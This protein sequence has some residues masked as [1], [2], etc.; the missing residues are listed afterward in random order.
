MTG[1]IKPNDL[2]RPGARH[3][4]DARV[5]HQVRYLGLCENVRVRRAGFAFRQPADLFV[6]RYK[7]LSPMPVNVFAEH[8]H[9]LGLRVGAQTRTGTLDSADQTSAPV[10]WRVAHY[11]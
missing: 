1:C 10:Y 3:F 9:T 7:M 8:F 6:R 4:D 5:Q 2:K 11:L